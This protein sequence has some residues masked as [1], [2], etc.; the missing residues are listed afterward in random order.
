MENLN[1]FK[2][3][4]ST[5]TAAVGAYLGVLGYALIVLLVLMILDYLTGFMASASNGTLS[6]AKGFKG[7]LK[8]LVYPIVIV[9]ALLI[10][11]II[12][13]FGAQFDVALPITTFFGTLMTLWFII[14]ESI[15]ILENAIKLDVKLPRFFKT[16]LEKMAK[17]IEDK[18]EEVKD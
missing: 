2:V 10:D 1:W 9:V 16:F 11:Y 3:T 7:I 13:L 5:I 17:H 18:G 15:S 12:L 4:I 8:K 6:S 14:N